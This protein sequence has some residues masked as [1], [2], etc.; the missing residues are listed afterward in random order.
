MIRVAAEGA[1]TQGDHEVIAKLYEHAAT[2]LQAKVAE[3]KVL[4]E[5]YEGKSYLYGTH[6]QD[7]QSHTHALIRN[8]E[9]SI[10]KNLQAAAVHRQIAGRLKE[11]H[12]STRAATPDAVSGL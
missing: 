4:L 6:A 3:K 11:N 12:A 2:K 10:R 5:H 7:L 8:Y 1:T 9:K